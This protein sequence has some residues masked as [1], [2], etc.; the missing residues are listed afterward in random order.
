M[1]DAAAEMVG[2]EGDGW[3]YKMP[4]DLM[5][6]GPERR[7]WVEVLR[8]GMADLKGQDVEVAEF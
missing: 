2:R 1:E 3:G 5:E 8:L 6:E 7:R 4:S